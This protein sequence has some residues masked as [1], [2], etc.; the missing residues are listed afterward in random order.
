VAEHIS[1]KELKHDR[2]KETLEHG[3]EAVYSHGQITMAI[4]LAVLVVGAL[5]G[6]WRL[7]NDHQTAQASAAFDDAQKVYSARVGPPLPGEPVDPNAPSYPDETTRA[8][9]ASRKFTEVANKYPSTNPGKLARYYNAL[10]LEAMEEHNQ[11]LEELKKI[12]S[13][14]DKELADMAKYQIAVLD[15]RTGKT[16]DA[17]KIYRSLADKGSIF[18]PRPL[19][20]LEL[21]GVLR[22]SK[23]DEAATVYRQIKQEFPDTTI[24]EE[25]DRGLSTLSPK[26]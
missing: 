6:G 14:S 7:Y 8:R 13:S 5:Y 26:S 3:A 11:A 21:A 12:S 10:C 1:R 18:V 22:E 15:T 25:A 17:V 20:L 4:L 2:I 24:A 9:E 19:V 16:D 23:P